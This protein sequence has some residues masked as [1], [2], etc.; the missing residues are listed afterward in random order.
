[1]LE[2]LLY[3]LGLPMIFGTVLWHNLH[4]AGPDPVA[5][6][7]RDAGEGEVLSGGTG[8]DLINGLGGDDTITGLGGDDTLLGGTGADHLLGGSG[9]DS[10]FGHEGD[11]RIEGGDGADYLS[12]GTGNDT[13][14]GGI[15]N[16]SI[17]G[18]SGADRIFAGAGDDVVTIWPESECDHVF[19]EDGA[20]TLDGS[21]AWAGFLGRGG[22]G[23]DLLIGGA[24]AD[25]LHGDGGADVLVGGFGA[26]VLNG[27]AG[28][29]LIDGGF[30]DASADTLL[31]GGGDDVLRLGA[32][33]VATG[34]EGADAFMVLG[35]DLT[36]F[37]LAG[38]AVRI[39]D[40]LPSAD[41]LEI[42]YEGPDGLTVTVQA[43]AGGLVVQAD[44]DDL[45]FLPGLQDGDLSAA[46]IR[47]VRLVA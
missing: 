15:G 39:E 24:G 22:E 30:G 5:T 33:D 14:F 8:N 21:A 10:L 19:L 44:G 42:R 36:D 18:S 35:G 23:A 7:P 26:D 2:T 40:F 28:D 3:T 27:G 1:M 17:V 29:D 16:D 4:G 45:A 20:D 11:D 41:S 9:R 43:V 13:L 32:R 25:T 34:G 12:G 47:L 31:G 46:Q 38:A 37:A 6:E